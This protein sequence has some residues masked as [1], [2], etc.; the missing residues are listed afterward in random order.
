MNILLTGGAG[1]L[2]QVLTP[3]L[4]TRGDHVIRLDIRAPE[5]GRGRFIRASITDRN[6][7]SHHFHGLDCLVHIAAWH[8]I[9]EVS[10]EKNTFDFWD[11]NV[12]GTFN[13]FELGVQ[14]GVRNFVFLSSTSIEERFGLYGH[15]KVLGEEVAKTY[16]AR[17]GANVI[18]LRPRAFIPHWN[19]RVYS[20][21][22]EWA[23]WY[24]PGAVHINDVAEAVR[25]SIDALND[26]R[27]NSPP[28]LIVDGAYEYTISDLQQWDSAGP[29]S[30]FRRTYPGFENLVKGYGLDPTLKPSMY[31]ISKTKAVLG[32]TPSFSLGTLLNELAHYGR[33]GP[34]GPA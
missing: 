4:V 31:D 27:F 30:T 8:G 14:A 25:L 22:V 13:V 21:Y 10:G 24:W 18:I 17:H 7:L 28:V 5:D 6:A 33:D 15:T 3:T 12:T 16:A 32:Y 9:H 1:D 26:R 23:K 19:R 20:D 34:P 11:V 29:G 2:A